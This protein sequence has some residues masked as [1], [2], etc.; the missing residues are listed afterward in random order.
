MA[1][2]ALSAFILGWAS[3][4]VL[5]TSIDAL[6]SGAAPSGLAFLGFVWQS[7][8]AIA[9][10]EKLTV[11]GVYLIG[12]IILLATRRLPLMTTLLG[13]LIGAAAIVTV[14]VAGVAPNG[15]VEH[16]TMLDAWN[17]LLIKRP[18]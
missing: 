13:V 7:L 3:F 12:V 18:S 10:I 6:M 15:A 4:L 9:P 5:L 16:A 11:G 2:A 14:K 8:G 1:R 17:C